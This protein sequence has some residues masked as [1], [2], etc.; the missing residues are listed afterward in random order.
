MGD[1]RGG[2]GGYLRSKVE[3]EDCVVRVVYLRH[4]DAGVRWGARLP[5]RGFKFGL[6]RVIYVLHGSVVLP[7]AIPA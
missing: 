1:T 6:I 5:G 2:R 3:D 4:L 7:A